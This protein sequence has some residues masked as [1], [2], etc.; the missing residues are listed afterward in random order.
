MTAQ[1]HYTYNHWRNKAFSAYLICVL[2]VVVLVP[3]GTVVRK[4]VPGFFEPGSPGLGWGIFLVLSCL[5]FV[6]LIGAP[7]ALLLAELSRR[8]RNQEV[9]RASDNGILFQSR[10][11]NVFIPW[12]DVG[13][14]YLASFGKFPSFVGRY[15]VEYEGGTFDFV[16]MIHGSRELGDR[17]AAHT[18]FRNLGIDAWRLAAGPSQPLREFSGA[19]IYPFRSSEMKTILVAGALFVVGYTGACLFISGGLPRNRGEL[20]LL[21]AVGGGGTFMVLNLACQLAHGGYRVDDDDITFSGA[22]LRRR[23]PWEQVTD[24]YLRGSREHPTGAFVKVGKREF[25]LSPHASG[26]GHL[27]RQIQQRAVHAAA[28]KWQLRDRKNA[29]AVRV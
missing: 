11:R 24:Y 29:G 5:A 27:L 8:R 1:R 18:D 28:T 4:I 20:F 10:T 26:L 13:S 17:I 9:I 15:V 19:Y 7:N 3:L 25:A 2:A 12:A 21:L 22:F 23:F 6:I 14:I 16:H